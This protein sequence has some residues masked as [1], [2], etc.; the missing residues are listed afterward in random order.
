VIHPNQDAFGV[1][2]LDYLEGRRVPELLR[3]ADSQR[4]ASMAVT[5]VYFTPRQR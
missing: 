2:L 3:S 4:K 5:K 1:A